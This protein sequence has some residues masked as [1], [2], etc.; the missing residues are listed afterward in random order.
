MGQY[1]K[2]EKEKDSFRIKAGDLFLEGNITIP[3]GL[4]GTKQ[5]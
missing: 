1:T 2:N 5:K 3:K 4:G